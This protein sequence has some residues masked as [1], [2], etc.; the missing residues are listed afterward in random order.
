[1]F[2][3]KE[4]INY[5]NIVV[6]EN[7]IMVIDILKKVVFDIIG[8]FGNNIYFVNLVVDRIVLL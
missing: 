6:C 5:V 4:K 1:M 2:F 8:F 7:V 3:L